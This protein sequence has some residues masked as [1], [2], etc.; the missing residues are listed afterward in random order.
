[1]T[2]FGLV[3]IGMVYLMW[4][5][6][7]RAS[8]RPRLFGSKGTFSFSSSIKLQVSSLQQCTSSD[9]AACLSALSEEEPPIQLPLWESDTPSNNQTA[10]RFS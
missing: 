7:V 9:N 1:M 4:S 5:L 2:K 8:N 10:F 3:Y 6:R